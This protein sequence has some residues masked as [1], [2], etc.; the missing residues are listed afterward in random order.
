MRNP[1]TIRTVCL[2]LALGF[3]VSLCACNA[4]SPQ[5]QRR[6]AYVI[7]TDLDRMVDDVD[8][9]L[10]LHQPTSLYNETVR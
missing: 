7:R 9:I 1:W 2:L 8:W 3:V 6:R 10:G 5:R 4:F